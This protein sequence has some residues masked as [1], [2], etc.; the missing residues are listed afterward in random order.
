MTIALPSHILRAEP[1]SL[2]TTHRSIEGEHAAEWTTDIALV[3]PIAYLTL[4]ETISDS[5]AMMTTVSPRRTASVSTEND[6]T[7]SEAAK[8]RSRR[9]SAQ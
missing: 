7:T 6:D 8:E 3:Q 9:S 4:P 1:I 5:E 2:S